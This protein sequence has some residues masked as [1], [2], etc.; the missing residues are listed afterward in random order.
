MVASLKNFGSNII[1]LGDQAALL[2]NIAKF[3]TT[4]PKA[5]TRCATRFVEEEIVP[6]GEVK[7]TSNSAE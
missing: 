5:L 4:L 2:K 3:S 7:D 6:K 1:F